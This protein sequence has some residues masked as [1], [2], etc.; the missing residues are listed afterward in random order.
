MVEKIGHMCSDKDKGILDSCD[1]YYGDT[2]SIVQWYR[3]DGKPV[4]II[5]SDRILKNLSEDFLAF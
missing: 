1:A 5:S 4:R 2:S 3:N